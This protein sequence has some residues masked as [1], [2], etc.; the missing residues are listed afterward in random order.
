MDAGFLNVVEIGQYFMTKILQN[1]HNSQMQWP[2]VSTLCHETKE[3]RN[4]K[5]GSEETP[6]LDPYWKLRLVACTANTEL[7]SE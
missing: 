3:H 6:N 2:V 1:F 4:Q 7:R 5:V